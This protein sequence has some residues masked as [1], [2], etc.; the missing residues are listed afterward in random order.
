MK[1]DLLSLNNLT[2]DE[3]EILL[4]RAQ[5]LKEELK[6]DILH[7]HLKGKTLG[8]LFEK[9]S[10]RTRVSFEVAM[11]QLGGH[12]IFLSTYDIQLQRGETIKDT[13][14]VL[15]S[16]IDGLVI[17][18]FAQEVVEEWARYA[19]IP[20][21]NGLTDLHH[22]CQI[23]SDL[24]TIREKKGNLKGL[25]LAYFG[26]GNNVAHSIL[27]GASKVG[28]NV[29][30]ASPKGF[31]PREEIVKA[32]QVEAEKHGSRVE[33]TTDPKA[34]A[35][36]ANILYTDVWVSMG[37]EME[38]NKMK[39]VF[40]PYQ[41]NASFLKLADPQV[42]V[43]HCLPAHRGEEIT[44]EVMESS[45]SVIFEQAENRLHLQ[46]ALLEMFLKSPKKTPSSA[47]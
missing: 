14:R 6:K 12:S 22:P 2:L 16:Y 23:L 45:R 30:I 9:A 11:A 31:Q 43:M 38:K 26:D 4:L 8:L 27:E 36:N 37:Q 34:A 3:I 44:E 19:T 13:A 29:I 42:L 20:V 15:S 21:I 41:V 39:D 46:K 40:R 35:R 28:M 1:R 18:T 33:V 5:D 17:R 24:M 10:T 25:T 7:P 32:A 47:R